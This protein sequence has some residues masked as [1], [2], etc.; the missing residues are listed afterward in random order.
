MQG[1]ASYKPSDKYTPGQTITI[2]TRAAISLRDPSAAFSPG[3]RCSKK[4]FCAPV[5]PAR[6]F[7]VRYPGFV[8]GSAHS[9]VLR[10]DASE[11]AS[12]SLS[13]LHV[14]LVICTYNRADILQE[15]LLAARQQSMAASEYEIIVVDNASSDGTR[16]VVE[17]VAAEQ[18]G[19]T[20][21]YLFCGE[22]GISRARNAGA[23]LA[24]API[25][26]YIDD[27]AIP[28]RD[29]LEQVVKAFEIHSDAGCIGGRIDIKL[30]S[31][32]PPWYCPSFDGY[33]SK[34]DLGFAEITRVSE[35]WQYPYGANVSFSRDAL[36]RIH[37]FDT[38]MGSIGRDAAG[39]EDTDAACRIAL[40]GFAIYYNPAA[41]VEHVIAPSRLYWR[42]IVDTARAGG[43]NWAFYQ[44]KL[45]KRDKELG[46]DLI[47]LGATCKQMALAGWEGSFG[48]FCFS[49][50]KCV[51]HWVKMVRKIRYR[52]QE[53]S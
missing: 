50:S 49:Y 37:F 43:N 42:Y 31:E 22:L 21:H 26:T 4:P 20:I 11:P 38:S 29:L 5:W 41:V 45:L 18:N 46:P 33:Y 7:R 10:Q 8:L 48:R 9:P 12:G 30:P 53:A 14:S 51:F 16:S 1:P 13:K 35:V 36:T 39:G 15:C 52:L 40:A 3:P 17:R 19:A 23:R 2:T 34:F 24:R 28:N 47:A 27:D 32:L 44:I 6:R 25:V